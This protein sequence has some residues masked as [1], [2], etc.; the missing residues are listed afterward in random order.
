MADGAVA[1]VGEEEAVA[2]ADLAAGPVAVAVPVEV[3]KDEKHL[4]G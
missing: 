2:S 4:S 3:G 1:V